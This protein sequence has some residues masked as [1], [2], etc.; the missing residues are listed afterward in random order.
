MLAK[1]LS[2]FVENILENGKFI[3]W[4]EGCEVFRHHGKCFAIDDDHAEKI[5]YCEV[6]LLDEDG[7]SLYV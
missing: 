6:E 4:Y 7:E 5:P 2:I 1:C 3:G